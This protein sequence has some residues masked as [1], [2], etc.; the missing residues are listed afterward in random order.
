MLHESK[1]LQQGLGWGEVVRQGVSGRVK[2]I[3]KRMRKLWMRV[4]PGHREGTSPNPGQQKARLVCFKVDIAL[5]QP[6]VWESVHAKQASWG[7]VTPRTELFILLPSDNPNTD[8][9]VNCGNK[10]PVF[11][12]FSYLKKANKVPDLSGP[13]HAKMDGHFQSSLSTYCGSPI[14]YTTWNWVLTTTCFLKALMI[15]CQTQRVLTACLTQHAI[16]FV[17]CLRINFY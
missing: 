2:R 6:W 14:H 5:G 16:V 8:A 11:I 1:F 3:R 10:D 7:S 15:W 12:W 17:D 9:V 4:S 13:K